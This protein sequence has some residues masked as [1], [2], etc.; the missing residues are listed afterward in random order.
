MDIVRTPLPIPQSH[1]TIHH[2]REPQLHKLI[3]LLQV[4]VDGGPN[5]HVYMT[6]K[7]EQTILKA[8]KDPH[9]GFLHTSSWVV[10]AL[11]WAQEGPHRDTRDLWRHWWEGPSDSSVVEGPGRWEHLPPMETRSHKDKIMSYA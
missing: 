9:D 8:N 4:A 3:Y 7:A 5:I 1:Q 10:P 2:F 6:I 11:P